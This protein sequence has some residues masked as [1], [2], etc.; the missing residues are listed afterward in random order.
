[1]QQS[2]D[3]RCTSLALGPLVYEGRGYNYTTFNCVQN[4]LCLRTVLKKTA[5]LASSEMRFV[6]ALHVGMSLQLIHCSWCMQRQVRET[7]PKIIT[8]VIDP[9]LIFTG[10]L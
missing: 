2:G 1:M 9:A 3:E 7:G 10:D 8:M 4:K 6:T 5:G